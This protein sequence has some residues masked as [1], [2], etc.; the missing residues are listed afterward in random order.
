MECD[1]VNVKR[2]RYRTAQKK[3]AGKKNINKYDRRGSE[4]QGKTS[5][6]SHK[7][8]GT[9]RQRERILVPLPVPMEARG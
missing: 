4:C 1:D 2:Y 6:R 9:A 7:G 3:Y 5:P 8:T